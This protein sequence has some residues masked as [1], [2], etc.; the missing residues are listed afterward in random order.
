MKKNKLFILL[1]LLISCGNQNY[2]SDELLSDN[3]SEILTNEN[4]SLEIS[5]FDENSKNISLKE[6]PF[7]SEEIMSSETPAISTNS[8]ESIENQSFSTIKEIKEKA[9]EFIGLENEVGVYESN[10][11][12]NINLK[13]L[14]C[15]DAITSKTGYGDRYKLLMSDGKDYIYVKTTQENYSYLKDYVTDQSVYFIS[16][17]ISI[18]NNEVEI[19]SKEKST[20]LPNESI[21]FD[22]ENIETNSLEEIYDKIYELKLNCKGIAY[23]KIIKTEVKCLAKDINNTNL[24]FG[25]DNKIINVHGNDKVTNKFT[26]GKSYMLIGAVSMYNFRPGLEFVEAYDLDEDIEFNCNNLETKK[27]SDLYKYTYETDED[28]TYP[29]YSKLFENPYIIEG[30]INSYIKDNKEYIVLEDEF[31]ENY[32]NTYQNAKDAKAAFFVNENYIKLNSTNSKYCPIYE[33]LELG[34]KLKV[35]VFP[36]LWNTQKYPQIYCYDFCAI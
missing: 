1:L 5:S 12:V 7:F 3:S 27:A 10:I 29:N 11:K 21:T 32:Y 31:N 13:L 25:K 20:Y 22:Y 14:A 18:Y 23:S 6:P 19:T 33:H 15:L 36:Y 9:K 35:V 34:S 24:Y 30:Y 17:T 8:E 4:T 26:S 2:I 16:G 28:D